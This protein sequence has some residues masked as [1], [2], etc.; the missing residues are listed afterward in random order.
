M[1]NSGES[2]EVDKSNFESA[3]SFWVSLMCFCLM[4]HPAVGGL[5]SVFTEL[6]R[7]MRIAFHSKYISG[8]WG[9]KVNRRH[10]SN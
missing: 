10:F 8:L 2:S 1:I 9:E 5:P 3:L 7:H 6:F 4:A